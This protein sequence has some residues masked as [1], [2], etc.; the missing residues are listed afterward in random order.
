MKNEIITRIRPI[1]ISFCRILPVFSYLM[2][3]NNY[4]IFKPMSLTYSQYKSDLTRQT[5]S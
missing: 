2:I 5:S 3:F 1:L 4:L